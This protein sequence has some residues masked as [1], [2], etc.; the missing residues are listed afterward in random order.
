VKHLR[1]G[2]VEI[3]THN[4]GFA[5]RGDSLPA[6]VVVSHVNL[7]DQCVEGLWAREQRA[8]SVQFHPE[9]AAGTHDAVYLFDDFMKLMADR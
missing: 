5:V 2:K 6:N 8:F 3:T 9:A 4:H 7:N 1:T